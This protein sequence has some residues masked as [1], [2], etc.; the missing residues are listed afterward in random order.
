[1][2]IEALAMGVPV[3]AYAHGGVDEQLKI[4]FPEGRVKPK[5]YLGVA[6]RISEWHADMPIVAPTQAFRLQ[7]MLENTLKVYRKALRKG[8]GEP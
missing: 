2:P 4:V 7:S 1:V 5:N 6:R 8:K 3:A